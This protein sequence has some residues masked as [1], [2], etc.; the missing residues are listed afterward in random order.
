M[1]AKVH[2][3]TIDINVKPQSVYS[4]VRDGFNLPVW[5]SSFCLFASKTEQGWELETPGGKV[6]LSFCTDNH[7]GV[8]DHTVELENGQHIYVPMRVIK[9]AEGCS[10]LFTLLQG[11]HMDEH[12]LAEDR[13]AI[14]AD[15]QRLKSM[16]E[17]G[18]I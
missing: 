17:E 5:A 11:P 4:Y 3:L 15:L 12:E 2:T 13:A 14:T 18:D 7:H 16:L 9:N 6:Q 1:F 10:L 8:L